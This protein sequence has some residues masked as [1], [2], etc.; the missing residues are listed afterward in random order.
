MVSFPELRDVDPGVFRRCESGW[1]AMHQ[2]VKDR[3]Y[4]IRR[5]QDRLRD[6]AG[7]ASDAAR[8]TFRENERRLLETADRLN[9]GYRLF[10]QAADRIQAAKAKLGDGLAEIG[11]WGLSVADDGTVVDANRALRGPE[12]VARL[13]E[14]VGRHQGTFYDALA[15]ANQADA[16]IAAAFEKLSPEAVGLAPATAAAT[17]VPPAGTSPAEVRRW[18]DSLSPAQQDALTASPDSG[19]GMLDGVPA[20]ARDRANRLQLVLQKADLLA[21]KEQLYAEGPAWGIDDRQQRAAEIDDSLRGIDALDKRLGTRDKDHED[22]YLLGFDSA[23]LGRAIVASGNPDTAANVATYVPGTYSRLGSVEGE[24][25]RSDKMLDSAA[26]AGSPSTSVITWIGYDA[27]QNPVLEAGFESYADDA[28][29]DLDRFQ[30][31]LRATRE[32]ERSHNTLVGHSYGTTVI[33][34]AARDEMLDVDRLALLASPGTGTNN[35]S[36]LNMP[37]GSVFATEAD[38]DIIRLANPDSNDFAVRATGLDDI[39]PHGLDPTDPAFGGKV[40]RSDPGTPGPFG[41]YSVAAHSEYW[42]D[43]NIALD[44]MGRIIA[45]RPTL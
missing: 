26:R 22:A 43:N 6:W 18:W 23:G 25:V 44:N 15:L 10:T 27:P 33:G 3:A 5:A 32:G 40:F 13:N 12:M 8:E 38:N 1:F 24:I 16:E 37:P 17:G 9:E 14:V 35:V 7:V 34:H 39:D 4:E 41:S 28:K 42:D 45:G 2:Q 21:R 30:D 11:A 31:G 36:E 29:K 20:T 19:V